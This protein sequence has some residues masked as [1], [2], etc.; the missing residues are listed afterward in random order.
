MK[1]KSK[2]LPLVRLTP[3]LIE[4]EELDPPALTTWPRAIETAATSTAQRNDECEEIAS[5]PTTIGAAT[6]DQHVDMDSCTVPS[7]TF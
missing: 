2:I 7:L 3:K 6:R 4:R 5:L 1:G